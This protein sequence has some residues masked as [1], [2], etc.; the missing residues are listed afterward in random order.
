MKPN[1]HLCE[2]GSGEEDDTTWG[3]GQRYQTGLPGSKTAFF[4]VMQNSKQSKFQN[5]IENWNIIAKFCKIV[6]KIIAKQKHRTTVW[7]YF[8][9]YLNPVV[10]KINIIFWLF[11]DYRYFWYAAKFR[12]ISYMPK[13][14]SKPS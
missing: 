4:V 1:N 3:L 10:S 5:S 2:K 7:N 6:T 14:H 9:T 13:T 8:F 11:H 12:L